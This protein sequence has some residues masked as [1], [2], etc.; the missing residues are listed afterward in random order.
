MSDSDVEENRGR[1]VSIS[2]NLPVWAIVLIAVVAV[3]GVLYMLSAF[4]PG[5]A[6]YR[7]PP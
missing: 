2:N 6:E 4:G 1:K 5:S 7:I 3:V